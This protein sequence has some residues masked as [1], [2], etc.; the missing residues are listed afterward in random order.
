MR[1]ALEALQGSARP[2]AQA[3]IRLAVAVG[4]QLLAH[5]PSVAPALPAVDAAVAVRVQLDGGDASRLQA[6]DAV[7]ASVAVVVV[8]APDRDT[9][10]A[11]V[12]PQ[13]GTL[14]A[15]RDADLQQLAFGVVVLPA[16]D[17][18]V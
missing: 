2:V 14:A 4:V 11:R 7:D 3:P 1:Q 13:V 9:V 12:R 18:A 5:E 16:V 8:V 6:L 10:R 17:A 15:A